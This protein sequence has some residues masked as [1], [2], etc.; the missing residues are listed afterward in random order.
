MPMW[1]HALTISGHPNR[2]QRKIKVIRFAESFN[3]SSA[4]EAPSTTSG[5][6]KVNGAGD[7]AIVVVV[8]MPDDG[9]R[10]ADR[11]GETDAVELQRPRL[12]FCPIQALTVFKWSGPYATLMSICGLLEIDLGPQSDH[13]GGVLELQLRL[14][15]L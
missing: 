13:D 10:R 14:K 8:S 1:L 4:N 7:V 3:E 9:G 12:F 6:K 15:N 5:I 11:Y 2:R